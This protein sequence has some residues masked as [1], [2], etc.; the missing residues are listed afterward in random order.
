MAR[1]QSDIE[2]DI[3]R[4]KAARGSADSK[5]SYDGNSREFRS[6]SEISAALSQLEAE[7]TAVTKGK[8]R[9][10]SRRIRTLTGW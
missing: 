1:S 9:V 7:L 4:L 3:D 2:A 5:V 6:E 8:R 10:M